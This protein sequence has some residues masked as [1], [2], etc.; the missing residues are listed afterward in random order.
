MI[1]LYCNATSIRFTR[2]HCSPRLVKQSATAR[3]TR[4]PAGPLH[5]HSSVHVLSAAREAHPQQLPQHGGAPLQRPA[6]LK[7]VPKGGH[8]GFC[9]AVSLRLQ[10]KDARSGCTY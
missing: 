3:Q 5:V 4:S 7:L 8:A 6:L 9:A 1:V 2:L 10:T